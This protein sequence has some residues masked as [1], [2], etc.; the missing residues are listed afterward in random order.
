[1][2]KLGIQINE[3]KLSPEAKKA[4]QNA[5]SK[6]QFMRDAIEFYV[7]H[8]ERSCTD[9]SLDDLKG[10]IKDIKSMLTKIC[11]INSADMLPF[12]AK[13]VTNNNADKEKVQLLKQ[14]SVSEEK[15]KVVS[16]NEPKPSNY[17]KDENKDTQQELS[18][19][20]KSE[21]E[22][23]LDASIDSLL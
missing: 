2:A 15:P 7:R 16:I 23:L 9:G 11:K 4:L 14:P 8:M 10:D 6:S 22:K 20:E 17:P 1:V 21:I 13:V 18:E 3:N 5:K 12:D 19:G